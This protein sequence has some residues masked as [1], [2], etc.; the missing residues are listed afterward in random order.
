MADL[1]SGGRVL[2]GFVP[3]SAW[4]SGGPTPTRAQPRALRGVH[5]LILKCWT[6]PGP[7]AGKA[8]L[9]LPPR[10]PCAC[11]CSGASADL[12]S[13]PRAPR[14]RSGRQRGYTYVPFCAVRHRAR[15]VRLLSPGRAQAGRTV[16]P[17]NLG[18][19]ICAVTATRRRRRSR[20]AGTS[21]G[22]WVPRCAA[23]GVVLAVGMRSRAATSSRSRRARSLAA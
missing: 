12:D 1:I 19:L 4:S 17:D 22:A 18:F 3:A 5:D 13:A 20:P 16:T 2:S 10:E 23:R 8:P 11:R 6:E 21:S 9:P 14:P 15:A 7:S